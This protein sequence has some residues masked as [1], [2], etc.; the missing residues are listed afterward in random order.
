M[1]HN[2]RAI[3]FD[4]DN[5]TF[6]NFYLHSGNDKFM[7]ESRNNY[8]CETIPQLLINK[9]DSGLV[10]AD[11]NCIIDKK[12]ALKNQSQKM[13]APLKRLVS[14]FSLSDCF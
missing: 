1:I 2:G 12:D 6:T 10:S 7:R 8:F 13:S 3:S 11:F 4:V 5:V 9:K 14:T